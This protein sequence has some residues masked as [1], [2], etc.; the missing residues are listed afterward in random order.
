[1]TIPAGEP[2]TR[3]SLANVGVIDSHDDHR[4]AMAFGALK[5]INPSLEVSNPDCVNKS[6]PDFW[7]MLQRLQ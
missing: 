5:V 6:F 2:F 1:M 7:K 3:E 4:I